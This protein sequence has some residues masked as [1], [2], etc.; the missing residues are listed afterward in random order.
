MRQPGTKFVV[1]TWLLL[2]G[3]GLGLLLHHGVTAGTAGVAPNQL[4]AELATALQ[5]SRQRPLLILCAHPQCPC[6]PSTIRELERARV[7]APNHDVRVL[8]YAPGTPPAEWDPV[9][10]TRLREFL[11]N[12]VHLD[13]RDGALASG[14][15]ALTSGHVLLYGEAGQLRFSGGVTAGRA[16]EGDNDAGRCLAG[17]LRMERAISA[18][19]PVFGCPLH[20]DEEAAHGTNCCQ[21]N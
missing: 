16:H 12:A 2:V 21:P 3:S 6:L 7:G 17:A 4:P 20:A 14:L 15:G 8:A 9:A 18:T 13:D 10:A 19:T 1:A 11:P 5:W